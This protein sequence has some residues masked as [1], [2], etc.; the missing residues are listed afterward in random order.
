MKLLFHRKQHLD[1]L[2]EQGSFRA[3]P[4]INTT[5]KSDKFL[6]HYFK[7]ELVLRE[8]LP[9]EIIIEFDGY[10]GHTRAEAVRLVKE[11]CRKL[12]EAE[13][14]YIV[15]DHE[16]KSPHI[17]IFIEGLDKLPY[18]KRTDYKKAF[19]KKYSTCP[20]KTDMSLCGSHLVALEYAPHFKYGR[21][22]R[23]VLAN[24]GLIKL[25][26][27]LKQSCRLCGLARVEYVDSRGVFYCRFCFEH[28]KKGEVIL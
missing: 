19:I 27:V 22:K 26:D 28:S 10:E 16:G 7:P 20:E 24:L 8:V 15:F 6:Y 25:E 21:E 17:H 13:F 14:Q 5:W 4:S 1:W 23:E 9:H 11:T 3:V 2:K 18:E 12:S